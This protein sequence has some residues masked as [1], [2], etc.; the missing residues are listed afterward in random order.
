MAI[1]EEK[2][3]GWLGLDLGSEPSIAVGR[4][5]KASGIRY[6]QR[7]SISTRSGR[8]RLTNTVGQQLFAAEP[9]NGVIAFYDERTYT[10][11][12]TQPSTSI[13]KFVVK[14]AGALHLWDTGFPAPQFLV[15]VPPAGRLIGQWYRGSLYVVD[16]NGTTRVVIRRPASEQVVGTPVRYAVVPLGIDFPGLGDVAP[17]LAIGGGA[18]SINPASDPFEAAQVYRVRVGI[19]DMFDR[20][21]NPGLPSAPITLTA[22]QQNQ[23][24]DVSW[25][26]GA[27]PEA[28]LF[29]IAGGAKEVQLWLQ[30]SISGTTTSYVLVPAEACVNG[31]FDPRGGGYTGTIRISTL[32]GSESW[33]TLEADHGF[34]HGAPPPLWDFAVNNDLSYGIAMPGIVV[35]EKSPDIEIPLTRRPRPNVPQEQRQ[36]QG[37][38]NTR[39]PPGGSQPAPITDPTRKNKATLVALRTDRT[40]TFLGRVFDPGSM[41]NWVG[42]SGPGEQGMGLEPFGPGVAIY[43]DRG[44]YVY[45]DDRGLQKT[46]SPVGLGARDSIVP[47]QGGHAFLASDTS[48][49]FFNGATSVPLASGQLVGLFK[50]EAFAGDYARFDRTRIAEVY[51]T[52]AKDRLYYVL[53][54]VNGGRALL[55]IDS[56]WGAPL[57]ALDD[58]AI[59]K[60]VDFL[61][62]ESRLYAIDAGSIGTVFWYFLEE[63]LADQGAQPYGQS[64]AADTPIPFDF[65]TYLIPLAQDH[66]ANAVRFALDIDPGGSAVD[67]DVTIDDDPGLSIRYTFNWLGRREVRKY[68]PP[69][70]KGRFLKVR[71]SGAVLGQRVRVYKLRLLADPRGNL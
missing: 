15:S 19:R 49:M 67:V 70:F 41:E 6:L 5:T 36:G 25:A 22:S 30:I 17:T 27:I 1:V 38:P 12:G 51:G 18:G 37:L 2:P 50:D 42:V 68:L 31:T 69:K 39:R 44:I 71:F 56:T 10:T 40:M 13:L 47:Y 20:T 52:Y 46:L 9:V 61:P 64:A 48:F 28:I 60:Q 26:A 21:S 62:T 58:G 53:P 55:V 35:R 4:L 33:P 3:V 43:T 66:T 57:I 63:G 34:D 7:G 29:D 59:Y 24:L 8:V 16:G 11:P 23:S 14:T 54:L 32:S 45:D 65:S